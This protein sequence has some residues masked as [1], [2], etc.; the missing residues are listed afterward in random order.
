MWS[1]FIAIVQK[2]FKHIFRDRGTL[3]LFFTLPI[4]QLTLF[5]FLD[6]NVH[7]LPTVVV[8]QDQSRESRELLDEMAMADQ[9]G[10]ARARRNDRT[11]AA[12][13]LDHD[14]AAPQ[15]G[16]AVPQQDPPRDGRVP[17]DRDRGGQ[18]GDC[19]SVRDRERASAGTSRGVPHRSTR[20]C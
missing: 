11:V 13:S 20:R 7:N 14:E 6:Q 5:G 10:R 12:I 18:P 4:M 17:H 1:S 8:D 9:H 19:R 2:E 3:I 16:G 15:P